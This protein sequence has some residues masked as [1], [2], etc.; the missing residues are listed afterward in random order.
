MRTTF[1]FWGSFERAIAADIVLDFA[2]EFIFAP[3]AY[4]AEGGYIPS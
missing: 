3:L 2:T 1:G 4:W